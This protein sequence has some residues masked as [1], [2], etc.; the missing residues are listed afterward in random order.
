MQ[1]DRTSSD[2]LFHELQMWSESTMKLYFSSLASFIKTHNLNFPRMMILFRLAH[3]DQCSVSDIGKHMDVS[4]PA[5]SQLLD[6]L[7]EAGYINRTENPDDRRIRNIEITEKGLA[8]VHEIES[9]LNNSM[10]EIVQAIPEKDRSGVA[11]SLN[12]LNTAI[13]S[14]KPHDKTF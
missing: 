8:L 9:K 6:K 3:K 5:A 12:T 13:R 11:K 7:V 10:H 2:E 4:S 1:T 14:L